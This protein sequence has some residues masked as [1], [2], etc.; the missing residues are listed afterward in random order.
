[1]TMS[2]SVITL[3]SRMAVRGSGGVGLLVKKLIL[4]DW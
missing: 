3:V 1:M 4:R 2:G